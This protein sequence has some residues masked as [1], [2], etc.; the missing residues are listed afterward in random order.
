MAFIGENRVKVNAE[1]AMQHLMDSEAP[2]ESAESAEGV[3]TAETAETVE[4]A[5]TVEKE[6]APVEKE[7]APVEKEMEK[8]VPVDGEN[9][10]EVEL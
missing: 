5:K 8:E 6:E 9:H 10:E 3:E 7:E 2:V 4:T 1:A